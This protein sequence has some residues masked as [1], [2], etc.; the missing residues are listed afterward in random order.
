MIKTPK[1]GSLPQ[2]VFTTPIAKNNIPNIQLIMF[3]AVDPSFLAI[4]PEIPFC[5]S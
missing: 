1:P 5:H 2:N 4:S 3:K